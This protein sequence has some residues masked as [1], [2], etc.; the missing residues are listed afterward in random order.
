MVMATG[1]LGTVSKT[2]TAMTDKPYAES[3]SRNSAPI[4]A[5]LLPLLADARQVLEIGSGTGQH[6]VHFAAA[7]PHL[8]WQ[9]SDHCDHLPGMQRWLDEAA[10]PNTPPP[11][12][13]Q[14]DPQA[15]LLPSPPLPD[16]RFDAV[17]TANTLHIMGW[18]CV[19]ALFAAL[20]DV[21]RD[22][23]RFFSYG[24]FNREGR[25]TSDSN[26]DFDAW[27]KSRDQRSGI[28]DLGDLQAL[29]AQHG[30]ALVDD[31]AMPANNA[32]LVW[33]RR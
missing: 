21:L 3:C 5:A 29:A 18:D 27:L 24:P 1:T 31:L 23:G 4:L 30:L 17:F 10:L 28:R 7:L 12:A 20:P 2:T 11:L 16:G 25:F 8:L 13:L 15:G 19:Q 33:Q 9:A 26:R 6:A 22:G 32:L 14:V